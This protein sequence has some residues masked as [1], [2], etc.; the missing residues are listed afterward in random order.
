MGLNFSQGSI[1]L[2]T[3]LVITILVV[4]VKKNRNLEQDVVVYSLGFKEFEQH[5]DDDEHEVS[6]LLHISQV[7]KKADT[8]SGNLTVV[9]LSNRAVSCKLFHHSI[10]SFRFKSIF[11]RM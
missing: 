2:L 10:D 3:F 1:F 6:G 5:G 11:R 8:S 4:I 7:L 9:T